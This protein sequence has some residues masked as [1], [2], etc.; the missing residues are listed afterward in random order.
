[1]QRE[2][3][4]N[5][6]LPWKLEFLSLSLISGRQVIAHRYSRKYAADPGT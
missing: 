2:A 5:S 1:M 6:S 4:V 3:V